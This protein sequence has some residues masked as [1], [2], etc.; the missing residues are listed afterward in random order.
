MKDEYNEV[1]GTPDWTG[2]LHHH[3][4]DPQ[5]RRY[6]RHRYSRPALSLLPEDPRAAARIRL[7]GPAR[8]GVQLPDRRDALCDLSQPGG[9][10]LRWRDREGRLLGAQYRRPAVP[11]LRDQLRAPRLP[12][13]LVP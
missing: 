3:R 12:R 5:C 2:V 11:D 7:L 6:A 8:S 4:N 9:G 13:A 10:A 1:D